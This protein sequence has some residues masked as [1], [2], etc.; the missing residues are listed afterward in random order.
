[1]YIKLNVTDNISGSGSGS[2]SGSYITETNDTYNNDS[3]NNY[4]YEKYDEYNSVYWSE[5]VNTGDL[6]IFN[7]MLW[8]F[9]K[10]SDTQGQIF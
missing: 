2:W 1:M 8:H 10:P 9:I 5:I 6:L 3:N 7:S 4:N